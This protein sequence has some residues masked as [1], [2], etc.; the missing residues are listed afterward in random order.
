MAGGRVSFGEFGNVVVDVDWAAQLPTGCTLD[1]YDEW[2][3]ASAEGDIVYVGVDT[4]PV[5]SQYCYDADMLVVPSAYAT[6]VAKFRPMLQARHMAMTA[7]G[8]KALTATT[9][10]VP[11]HG[12][13]T[14]GVWVHVT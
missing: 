8:Q 3:V 11:E 5:T 12:K 9:F 2:Q 7:N 10:M 1:L 14:R 4:K 13:L 6:F